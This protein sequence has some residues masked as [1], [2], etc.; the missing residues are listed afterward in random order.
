[1]GTLS[2]KTNIELNFV[3]EKITNQ[4]VRNAQFCLVGLLLEKVLSLVFVPCAL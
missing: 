4:A 2:L 3:C 1:M